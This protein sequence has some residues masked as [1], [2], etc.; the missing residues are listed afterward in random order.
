MRATGSAHYTR[1]VASGD[2]ST[3][4]IWGR[5]HAVSSGRNTDSWLAETLLPV[6][7]RNIL[8]GRVEVVDKDE[9]FHDDHDG[10]AF[11]IV[12]FTAGYT[13]EIASLGPV[14]TAIGANATTY[15]IPRELRPSYGEHP[16]G[17]NIFLRFRLQPE[18]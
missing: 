17:L 13:R 3:S 9:L 1:P 10:H 5:N 15:A 16:A 11:R 14:R 12:G 2:W 4:F 7:R 18:Q 8:T 6:T